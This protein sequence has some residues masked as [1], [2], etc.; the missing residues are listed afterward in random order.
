MQ[1]ARKEEVNRDAGVRHLRI[2]DE[3]AGQRLDNFLFR[4]LKGVPKSR[5]YRMLREGEVRVDGR[6]AKPEQRLEPGNEVRIPPARVARADAPPAQAR[7]ARSLLPRILYRDEALLVLDKPAGQ[8]VHGGSG[9]SLGIIEQLRRE[10]PQQRFMELVHRLDKETSGLLLVALKRPALVEL[11]R[12]LRAGETRKTYLALAL[13]SWRERQRHVRLALR[14]YHTGEGERRVAVDTDGQTAHTVFTRLGQHGEF[15][16]VEAELKTGRTHQIRVHLAAL[17]H[18]IAGDD[19]Y[20]DF[21]RNRELARQGL[22]RMFLHAARL[23]LR[24]PQSGVPL[25]LESP[26]P[27]DLRQFLDTLPAPENDM[28]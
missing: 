12:M 20:G 27:D 4:Q 15:S 28:P 9:V 1:Q 7:I 6:R 17:G 5:V 21:E 10:L 19:K 3:A 24:H 18:P 16:L 11:H 22:R 25:R 2:G 14:K 26:L 23:E 13:G 8:A